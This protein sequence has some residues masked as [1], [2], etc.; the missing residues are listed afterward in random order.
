VRRKIRRENKGS[1]GTMSKEDWQAF[2]DAEYEKAKQAYYAGSTATDFDFG[3]NV[4]PPVST[5]TQQEIPLTESKVLKPS[6]VKRKGRYDSREERRAI[7]AEGS[8]RMSDADTSFDFGANVSSSRVTTT[9]DP[10][11]GQKKSWETPFV[12]SEADAMSSLKDIEEGIQKTINF[13]Q[14]REPGE[15]MDLNSPPPPPRKPPA[16]PA[17][18]DPGDPDNDPFKNYETDQPADK[19]D[20]N[21]DMEARERRD[22][23]ALLSDEKKRILRERAKYRTQQSYE[24]RKR[25][26]EL[27]SQYKEATQQIA[28]SERTTASDRII[29]RLAAFGIGRNLGGSGQLFAGA[30]EYAVFRPEEEKSRDTFRSKQQEAARNYQTGINL[31]EDDAFRTSMNVG[32]YNQ[33]L[34]DMILSAQ[35]GM[36]NA[37]DNAERKKVLDSFLEKI[38]DEPK[39]AAMLG[40]SGGGSGGGGISSPGGGGAGGKP[41]GPLAG[42]FNTPEKVTTAM[43]A[44]TGIVE[45][46]TRIRDAAMQQVQAFGSMVNINP[47]TQSAIPGV[48]NFVGG[49]I[50]ATSRV[51]GAGAGA[52]VGGALG[53]GGGPLGM[54]IGAAVG[55]SV[56]GLVDPV[57]EAIKQGNA[58][59]ENFTR[60]SMDFGTIGVSAQEEIATLLRKIEA[61]F[62]VS[63]ETMEFAEAQG[64]LQ[65]A[66]IGLQ[67][68]F[69]KEFG[70]YLADSVKALTAIIE[71]LSSVMGFASEIGNNLLTFL[72]GGLGQLW[73]I[74]KTIVQILADIG[75]KMPDPNNDPALAQEIASFFSTQ[76]QFQGT[77]QKNGKPFTRFGTNIFAGP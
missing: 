68:A 5:P 10:K 30:M 17:G 23:E 52:A 44:T 58:L 76:G 18:G 27:R 45:A 22:L 4:E 71:I 2:E 55:A 65:R 75:D 57:V 74:L 73:T 47:L 28:E 54:L 40:M 70:P 20:P 14:V 16:P 53:A 31:L 32:D 1:M 39:L 66:L 8:G 69:I 38:K 29:R 42:M 6:T 26:K 25:R 59:M 3:A 13:D 61:D 24:F 60:N 64:E 15:A 37:P 63:A 21:Q 35:R 7:K 36:K 62:A 49:G 12:S 43:L 48:S 77:F 33:Q 46:I 72:P 19:I 34:D 9:Y 56:G 67:E 41:P 50:S 11:A 51:A